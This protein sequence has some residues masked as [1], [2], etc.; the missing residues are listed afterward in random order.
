[1]IF[2]L[3]SLQ[4]TSFF[5]A[6]AGE[7]TVAKTHDNSAAKVKKWAFII[8]FDMVRSC[9]EKVLDKTNVSQL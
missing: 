8:L 4:D 9:E 7:L 2:S 3:L 1:M 6:R 5:W